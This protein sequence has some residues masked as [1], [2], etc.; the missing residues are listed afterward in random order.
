M[1]SL[2]RV[3]DDCVRLVERGERGNSGTKILR[4]GG[5]GQAVREPAAQAL[6]DAVK[7]EFAQRE[8]CGEL[9]EPLSRLGGSW[10]DQKTSRLR[11]K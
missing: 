1:T 10:R 2:T 11:L 5:E 7:P 3:Q 9:R 4:A 6:P 8:P